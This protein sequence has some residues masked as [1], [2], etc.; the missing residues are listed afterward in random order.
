MKS[1]LPILLFVLAASTATAQQFDLKV[2]AVGNITRIPLGFQSQ[3]YIVDGFVMP[4]SIHLNAARTHLLQFQLGL[5]YNFASI[6]G[7][8][9]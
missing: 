4:G 2:N 8:A 1:L 7:K 3:I 6:F 9:K 5:S